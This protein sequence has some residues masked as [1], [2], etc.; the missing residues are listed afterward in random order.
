MSRHDTLRRTR[1]VFACS[2][3]LLLAPLTAHAE[4]S[5]AELLDSA[6]AAAN[7]GHPGE[8][9]LA[10]HRAALLDPSAVEAPVHPS[11]STL[12]PPHLTAWIFGGGV[13]LGLTG[14]AWVALSGRRR[15]ALAAAALGL[16][17]AT[18]AAS[19]LSQ[20]ANAR[21]LAIVMEA[22][23]LRPSPALSAPSTISLDA[24]APV[25]IRAEH[26]DFV[27]ISADDRTGWVPRASLTRVVP[28]TT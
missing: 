20:L 26:G 8:A 10:R 22:T 27:E 16:T 15:D 9:A 25:L 24:G 23:P 17:V 7:A 4:W 2:L 21:D 14:I 13:A 5:S 3:A 18:A 11:V 6:D 28:P 12:L 19:P 1:L